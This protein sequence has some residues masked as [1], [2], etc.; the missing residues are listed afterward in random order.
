MA[1]R[2]L[3]TSDDESIS[4]NAQLAGIESA[5]SQISSAMAAQARATRE[6]KELVVNN[7]ED[8]LKAFKLQ[9]NEMDQGTVKRQGKGK[10]KVPPGPR[11]S[12]PSNHNPSALRTATRSNGI[13]PCTAAGAGLGLGLGFAGATVQGSL[14]QG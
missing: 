4:N 7:F 9:H 8:V 10:G 6:V 14:V 2:P 5:I 3:D 1:P 11:G 12:L 13:E